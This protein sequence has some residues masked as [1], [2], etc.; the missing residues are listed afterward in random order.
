M[1]EL[2]GYGLDENGSVIDKVSKESFFYGMIGLFVILNAI[3][4]F[5]PKLLETK[6]H[7]GL[8]RIFPI[9]DTYRDYFLGWFYSF[10]GIVNLSL[11]VMVFYTHAIN[12]QQAIAANEFSFFF[13]LIPVLFIIWI[14]GLFAIL[15]GKFK[16]IKK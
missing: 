15:T 4:L 11:S 5:P 13:Y 1:A 2:V 12:N 8:H 14:I 10:G 9:G 6:M 3:V 16:Q 7:N